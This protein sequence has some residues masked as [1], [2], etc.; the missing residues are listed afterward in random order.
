MEELQLDHTVHFATTLFNVATAYRTAGKYEEA[1]ANYRRALKFIKELPRHY[2][3]AEPS[4]I[5]ILLESSAMKMRHC[6]WK[7]DSG[8][9]KQPGTRVEVA[10]SRTSL[11]L[12]EL[13]M[14][15][16][17]AAEKH[18]EL[19]ISAFKE[20]G[21][22][23]DTHYSAA[24]AGLGEVCYRQGSLERSLENYEHALFEVE[25]HFGRKEGYG[26]LCS[27][28]AAICRE[29]GQSAK[30]K[31]MRCSAKILPGSLTGR[32]I[33]LKHMFENDTSRRTQ[34]GFPFDRRCYTG[35][36]GSCLFLSG[37]KQDFRY[38]LCDRGAGQ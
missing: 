9:E 30:L 37:Q 19:A 14:D 4:S 3:L 31:S 6:F 24:L 5:S 23:T 28:C 15:K 33:N 12:I 34:E 38:G 11:A 21:G 7:S 22:K 10:T 25:K 27:N 20:D 35:S 26:L 29:L 18:L 13:K 1:L 16:L 8:M 36:G 32:E 17:E 2:R